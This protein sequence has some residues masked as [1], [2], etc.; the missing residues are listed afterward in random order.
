LILVL[1][2]SGPAL[3]QD[4]TKATTEADC[5]KAG[6]T[7]V[8]QTAHHPTNRATPPATVTKSPALLQGVS[9]PLVLC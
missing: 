6:D 9:I 8:F 4:V 5:E 3:A 1:A 2:A 7:S